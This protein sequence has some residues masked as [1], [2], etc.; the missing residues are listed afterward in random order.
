MGVDRDVREEDMDAQ[1]WL[2]DYFEKMKQAIFDDAVTAQIIEMRDMVCEAA[3]KGNKVMFAGNGASASISSH[4]SVDYT[5][6][7]KIRS[8]SFNEPN[9]I[10]C[11]SNDYGFDRWIEEA[12]AHQ[13]DAGDVLVLVSSSGKSMNVINAANHARTRDIP[14]VTFTGFSSDNPLRKLGKVNFWVNSRS[15]NIVECTH[16]FWL[17]AACDLIVGK[18]EYEV[19]R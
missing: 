14:V 2:N 3:G 11:F 4:C 18:A 12:V 10:T 7:A 9:L 16:M 1:V 8:V 19:E 6:Q 17:M 15:Y 13:G 5:K